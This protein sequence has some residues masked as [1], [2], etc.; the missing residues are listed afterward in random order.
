MTN[1]IRIERFGKEIAT[2]NRSLNVNDV[3]AFDTI[4]IFFGTM[5]ECGGVADAKNAEHQ[6]H[7]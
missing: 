6:R 7:Q 4:A 2:D 1:N 3:F 5:E